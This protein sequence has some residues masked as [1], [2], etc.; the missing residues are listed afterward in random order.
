MPDFIKLFEKYKGKKTAIYGLGVET[1]NLLSQING[2]CEIIGLLD[3]FRE[4]GLMYGHQI[5]SLNAAAGQ[6]VSLIIVA[7]RPAS[8]RAISKRIGETCRES[9]IEL[10][11]IRGSNLL[12]PVNETYDFTKLSGI[13]RKELIEKIEKADVVSFD[14]FD[15]LVMRQTL[16]AED[17]IELVNCRLK[18]DNIN[19]D[20]FCKRRLG[21]EKE[22]SKNAAPTLEEIYRHML[23][24]NA[25]E[26]ALEVNGITAEK[27][28]KLEWDID[29]NLLIPREEICGILRGIV[30]KG[31]KVYIVSDTYYNK[32]QLREILNK[33]GIDGYTDILASSDYKTGKRQGLFDI[34]KACEKG[35]NSNFLHIGDDIVADVESARSHGIEG[36]QL[37]SA[38][39]LIDA[40]GGLGIQK[41]DIS[42]SDRI[43]LGMLVS[44]I[45]N[46]PFWFENEDRRIKVKSAYDIGYLM[47]API[48]CDFVLWLYKKVNEQSIKNIWFGARDGYLIKKIY[49]LTAENYGTDDDSLYFLTSRTAAVRSGMQ[50]DEDIRYV[51][52]MKFSGT[53]E[54]NLYN[55]FGIDAS[56]LDEKD[57]S[58]KETGLLKYKKVIIDKAAA[59]RANYLK[60]IGRLKIKDGDTAFFDF[61]AK[62]T[63]QMYVQRLITNR[64]KGFYFMQLE[65]ENM[66]DKGLDIQ[67]FYDICDESSESVFENYYII[68]TILT[69][70]H[71]TVIDFDESGEPIY[72]DESR[73]ESDIKCFMAV[74][75][76]I[77]DYYRRYL[78]LCPLTEQGI[79]KDLSAACLGLIRR[80][81]I[82]DKDF[83]GMAVEDAFFNRMTA[84]PDII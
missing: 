42:V 62:G 51:D 25:Y 75:E 55:R 43:K 27:L 36:C 7:A 28:A 21:A 15:T 80:I 63:T 13:T 61:V 37:Y 39:E 18:A 14:L 16:Y 74:Q 3:S 84:M 35:R 4:S 44:K 68:E 79:N 23:D 34:L 26:D 38:A 58:P 76:G 8:C 33:C 40:V 67:A 6:G 12:Q 60:Y 32:E 78:A 54:D 19:I 57:I 83:L 11:D 64:L 66:L 29:Y 65:P 50:S 17:V 53:L 49:A 45:F 77:L 48:I 5:M 30:S 20:C 52:G 9:G 73:K 31:R 56:V 46:S 69:A 82:V 1:E 41:Y 70:P 22:L 72:V 24:D 71:P 59:A 10:I 81:Q 47:C 2:H